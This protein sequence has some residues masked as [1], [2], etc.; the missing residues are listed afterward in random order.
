MFHFSG[1]PQAMTSQSTQCWSMSTTAGKPPTPFTSPW[2]RVSRMAAWA[3]RP[4]SG[5]SWVLGQ[6][7]GLRSKTPCLDDTPPP[8]VLFLQCVLHC[9]FKKFI[10]VFQQLSLERFY[11]EA[12]SVPIVYT[13]WSYFYSKYL[14]LLTGFKWQPI[15]YLNKLSCFFHVIFSRIGNPH[16]VFLSWFFTMFITF[17]S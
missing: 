5:D 13:H 11:S 1:M 15:R 10:P 9:L 12:E 2:T 6:L 16:L 17:L 14:I 8:Q 3:S 7:Y 4:M